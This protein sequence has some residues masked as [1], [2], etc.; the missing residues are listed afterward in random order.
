MTIAAVLAAWFLAAVAVG[1]WLK[2]I[3]AHYPEG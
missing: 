3:G 2:H 1:K